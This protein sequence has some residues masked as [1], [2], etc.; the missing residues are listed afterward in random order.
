MKVIVTGGA[1]FI[2][3]HLVDA[4]VARGDEVLV[5]DNLWAGKEVGLREAKTLREQ[6]KI[7]REIR[8][9]QENK[10]KSINSKA[11][12]FKFD[13]TNPNIKTCFNGWGDVDCVFHLAALP[14]VEYSFSDPWRT[15]K[16]NVE[17]TL[18]V[19]ALAVLLNA[20]RLIFSSSS[21]VYGGNLFLPL[22][23]DIPANPLSPYALQKYAGEKYCQMLCQPEKQN[24]LNGAVCLRY[25]NVYG[26]RQSVDGAY[27]S[28]IPLFIENRK[29]GAVS[30]I[31]GDGKQ[32]RDFTWV[33]DVVRATILAAESDKVGNG[34]VINI[35][36]GKNYSVNQL[37]EMIGGKYEYGPVRVEPRNSLADIT[38]AKELLGWE[39]RVFLEQ[40]ITQLKEL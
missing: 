35:G 34:E 38:R 5:I 13:I 33:G 30:T 16:V 22:K 3:G 21:S 36:G 11:E 27:A 7:K 37:A 12:L 14:R 26:P 20:K 24:R 19:I 31:F 8:I 6:E 28:A 29:A 2:G 15:N 1:G 23:E 18:N 4:L 32:T 17:G 25:F 40:G 39:P 9:L 10:R